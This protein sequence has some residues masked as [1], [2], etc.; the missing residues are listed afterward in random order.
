MEAIGRG[1]YR[2]TFGK[3]YQDIER[4]IATYEGHRDGYRE[5]YRKHMEGMW[6][7]FFMK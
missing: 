5:G 3:G 1:I 6:S 4:D 2:Q 7:I